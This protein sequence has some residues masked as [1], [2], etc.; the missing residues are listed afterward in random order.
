M[1]PE[2]AKRALEIFQSVR[3]LPPAQAADFVRSTCGEDAEMHSEVLRLLDCALSDE[4]TETV[5][6]PRM[7]FLVGQFVSGRYRILR[8]LGRGGMGQ[9]YEAEDMELK[10]HVA[11]KTLLPEIASDGRM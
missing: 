6:A 1:T 8:F 10:E 11:V 7:G 5:P 4:A 9:V 3:A 2:S